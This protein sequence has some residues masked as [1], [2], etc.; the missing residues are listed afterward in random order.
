[1]S[2]RQARRGLVRALI[3]LGPDPGRSLRT[4]LGVLLGCQA[5]LL[6]LHFVAAVVLAGPAARTVDGHIGGFDLEAES[7]LSVWFSSLQLLFIAVLCL[8][9]SW[10][11]REGEKGRRALLWRYGALVFTVL[12]IDE[13]AVLHEMFGGSMVRFFPGIP[14]SASLWWAIPY[15]VLI[16]IFLIFLV[17]T[18]RRRIGLL[19]LTLAGA[20]LWLL[21]VFLEIFRL[22]PE[23]ANVALEEG[24]EMLGATAFL[25]ALGFYLIGRAEPGNEYPG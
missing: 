23:W 22:F 5:V 2:T 1:M 3:G 21:S 18:F 20:G 13:T 4:L 25:A 12:S 17:L 7:S 16:G 8:F 6:L 9:V 24:A 14:L 11:D 15:G 10:F 19:V